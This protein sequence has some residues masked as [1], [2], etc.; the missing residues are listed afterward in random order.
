M[1]HRMSSPISNTASAVRLST[2][3]EVKTLSSECT[4]VDFAVVHSTERHANVLQLIDNN[5]IQYSG[6][7]APNK[8][9]SSIVYS[10]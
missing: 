8:N 3:P 7:F 6:L 2:L 5:S 1:Q 4:L 9:V 10:I